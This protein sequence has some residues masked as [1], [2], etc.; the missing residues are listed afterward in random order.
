[1]KGVALKWE[2]E[3]EGI[4]MLIPLSIS[5]TLKLTI[6]D[7]IDVDRWRTGVEVGGC[8]G[9]RNQSCGRTK[10]QSLTSLRLLLVCQVT[11]NYGRRRMSDLLQDVSQLTQKHRELMSAWKKKN[12][13][14]GA[15]AGKNKQV[16]ARKRRKLSFVSFPDIML[17]SS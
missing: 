13:G 17:K 2:V 10:G 11:R 16:V 5:L 12:D 9:L 7:Q 1:M 4:S 8:C 15:A 3:P 14:S 6:P